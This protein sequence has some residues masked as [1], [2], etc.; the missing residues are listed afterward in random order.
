M[1]DRAGLDDDGVVDYQCAG[2]MTQPITLLGDTAR[3]VELVL[4]TTLLR[5]GPE[6]GM[7]A[8]AGKQVPSSAAVNQTPATV[9]RYCDTGLKIS[10][11]GCADTW[12][13]EVQKSPGLRLS[14][15]G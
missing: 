14:T 8:M 10:S 7:L 4:W 5:C 11:Q 2:C 6:T 15:L 3:V 9:Q 13:M 12:V 1:L